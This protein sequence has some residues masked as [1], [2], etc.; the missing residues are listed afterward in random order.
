[1]KDEFGVDI[2]RHH[3][4]HLSASPVFQAFLVQGMSLSLLLLKKMRRRLLERRA[5]DL[6]Q[7]LQAKSL[8]SIES[9]LQKSQ[10]GSRKILNVILRADVQ[11]SLEALKT[12]LTKIQSDKVD[13]NIIFT[14]I[15]GN[16]R[17]GCAVSCSLRSGYC[18]L[19]QLY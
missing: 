12:A 3:L 2:D 18:G 15:G 10:E 14:G 19:P 9:L 13:L 6:K 7:S 17:I 16:Y 8:R 5:F 1:M 11:G 4:R